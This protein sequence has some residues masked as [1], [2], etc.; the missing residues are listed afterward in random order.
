M[1]ENK[2]K[3]TFLSL[4]ENEGFARSVVSYFILNLNPS[5]A[6]ISD[7]KTAVSEAVTN[8][9]VHGYPNKVGEITI[10]CEINADKELHIKIKDE[11]IGIDNL[12]NALEPFYTTKN[13]EERSGMGFTIMKS[14]MDDVHVFSQKNKGT[15]VIMTKKFVSEQ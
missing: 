3:I 13:D 6:D 14:F 10:E 5:V 7:V 1:N 4:S 2:F 8:C 11:G 15:E 12:E 9:I